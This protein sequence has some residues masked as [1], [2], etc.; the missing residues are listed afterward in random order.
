MRDP[1]FS[2]LA[3]DAK[4]RVVASLLEGGRVLFFDGERP[5]SVDDNVSTQTLLAVVELGD[6]AFE[7]PRDGR[8][9]ACPTPS[10]P[11]VAGGVPTWFRCEM[12]TGDVVFDG[13]VGL[14]RDP[15]LETFDAYVDGP[16]EAEAEFSIGRFAYVER[17]A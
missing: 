13:T 1:R 16:C 11:A 8:M 12:V 10:V 14:R 7:L 3:A 15:L 17:R 4:C 6:P 2:V 9:L 5:A